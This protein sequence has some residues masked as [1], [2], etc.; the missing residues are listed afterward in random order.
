MTFGK[1]IVCVCVSPAS[2]E[3]I[4]FVYSVLCSRSKDFKRKLTISGGQKK[5]KACL[6]LDSHDHRKGDIDPVARLRFTLAN[7]LCRNC[8]DRNETV[9][10]KI[11]EGR[12]SFES[13]RVH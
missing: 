5:T 1:T 13:S 12:E 10:W 8:A 2:K 6:N 9:V 3:Q 7:I 4:K 11:L